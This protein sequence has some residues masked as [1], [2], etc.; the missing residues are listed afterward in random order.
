MSLKEIITSERMKDQFKAALPQHLSVDRFCRIAI[1]ALT[2]NPKLIDC[3][4]ES[5]FKCLLDLSAM[6]LEPDGRLAH[7][8]PYGN[9][10]TLVVDYKG[11]ADLAMRS[12][13]LSRIHADV[14]CENDEF[15]FNLGRIEVHKIDFR[16][17][18][19]EPFAAYAIAETKDGANFVVVLGKDEIE[20]IRNNSQGY[21]AA[22]KYSKTDN[23]WQ[24]APNE[25][26][27]KT[28]FRRLS[29]WLPLS[30]EFR[31]AL[32]KDE[33]DVPVRDVTPS[34]NASPL[35]A[36]PANPVEL[37]VQ[38]ESS[39]SAVSI[40]QIKDNVSV[41][42]VLDFVEKNSGDRYED[43]A[44]VPEEFLSFLVKNWNAVKEGAK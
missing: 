7:L 6:G 14:V 15:S 36:V 35:F 27:K 40:L 17:P 22:L 25:M 10:C 26:W 16:N 18:R 28:A 5:L 33:E 24:V 34:M 11:L 4:Q 12:G 1:T 39:L 13:I 20:T 2:R 38:T 21:K 9:T 29:K 30:A 8:I 41:Q 31:E 23:P 43:V 37:E 32:E 42:T 44:D 19:G 3:T